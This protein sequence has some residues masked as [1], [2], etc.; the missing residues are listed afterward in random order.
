MVS[1][2]FIPESPRFLMANGREEEAHAFLTKYHGNG[3]SDSKL[4]ALQIA[5]MREGIRQDGIDKTWWDC[6]SF[7][8][9]TLKDRIDGQTDLCSTTTMV[10]GEWLRFS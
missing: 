1:V 2:F 4:V 7:L 8:L 6:M 9:F 10:D 3:R 5:E